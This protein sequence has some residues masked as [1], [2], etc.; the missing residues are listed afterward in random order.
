MKMMLPDVIS[1]EN[2]SQHCHGPSM[3]MFSVIR[4]DYHA[5][6]PYHTGTY[7]LVGLPAPIFFTKKP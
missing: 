5:V 6:R 4:T 1:H 7:Y 2:Q 3:F